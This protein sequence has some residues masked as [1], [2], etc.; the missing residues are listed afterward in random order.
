M[1]CSHLLI[2]KPLGVASIGQVH[3]ATLADGTEVVIKVQKPG[4]KEQVTED[5]EILRQLGANA[6]G[7]RGDGIQ[8]YDLANLVEEISDT[9]S[10]ELDY[11]REGHSAEHFARFFKDDPTMHIPKVFWDYTTNRVITLERIH[12][13]N[14]LDLPGLDKA[15]FDRKELAKRAADIWVRDGF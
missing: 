5:L 11:I 15:N 2:P 9:M 6:A 12:G 1:S 10:G 13:I 3:A 14:I 7:H 4:V 8:H